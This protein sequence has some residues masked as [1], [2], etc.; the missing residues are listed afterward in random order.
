ML[1][2][3][4]LKSLN[5]IFTVY[6]KDNIRVQFLGVLLIFCLKSFISVGQ[7]IGDE[8]LLN[9]IQSNIS[10]GYLTKASEENDK[11]KQQN[12]SPSS[13][14]NKMSKL[15][16]VRISG[17]GGDYKS[18]HELLNEV[19]RNDDDPII[20]FYWKDYFARYCLESDKFKIGVDA[21]QESIELANSIGSNI[22]ID[23]QKHISE[24]YIIYYTENIERKLSEGKKVPDRVQDIFDYLDKN[25][26][27]ME[28]FEK[29]F[30]YSYKL[31]FTDPNDMVAVRSISEMN[32]AFGNEYDQPI[33]VILGKMN[34]AT[35]E[36]DMDVLT[37]E[38]YLLEAEEKSR[39]IESLLY[40]L[41]PLYELMVHYK[42][43][44]QY[45]KAVECG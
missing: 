44:G 11:L 13:F 20:Q 29:R 39:S 28:P 42:N 7:G 9:T 41:M 10:A 24:L 21:L 23:I 4:A 31:F 34:L 3:V 27:R 43:R 30:L 26:Y 25:K 5:Q 33:S 2:I 38:K 19:D 12:P 36:K 16:S 6:K 45:Q 40:R 22:R 1:F 15:L 8:K 37:A 14:Y 32:I 35:Y 17:L 18:M